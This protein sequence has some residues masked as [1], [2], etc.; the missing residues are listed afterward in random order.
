MQKKRKLKHEPKM[1]EISKKVIDD[2]IKASESAIPYISI[3]IGDESG[4]GNVCRNLQQAI[5]AAKGE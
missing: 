3:C 2:L 1:V 5:A 4:A